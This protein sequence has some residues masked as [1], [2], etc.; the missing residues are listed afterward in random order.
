MTEEVEQKEYMITKYPND[1]GQP[2]QDKSSVDYTG[3]ATVQYPNGDVYDG[4]FK[5]GVRE[6]NGTYTYAD[7]NKYEGSWK[8]NMK[9]GIG[10][11]KYGASAEY[12]GHFENGK[13]DGEGLYRF[14]KTNDLYSGSW[15]NGLKH[16]NG[17]LRFGDTGVSIKGKWV[18]GQV[19]EG[20]WILPNDTYFEGRFENNYPKG[21]GVWHFNNGSVLKGEFTQEY[22]EVAGK[23][24]KE[25]VIN[26]NTLYKEETVDEL[27]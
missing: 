5:N 27:A 19:V 23:E 17:T 10:T 8:N 14:L 16:G 4:M 24:G 6:G 18:N 15:K 25:T 11:M 2:V 1:G 3:K 21:E 20:R 12:T 7:G 13:R 9:H 26:W 22:R